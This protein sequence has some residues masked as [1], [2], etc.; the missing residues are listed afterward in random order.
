MRHANRLAWLGF[1]VVSLAGCS[2]EA[3]TATCPDLPL[4]NL[5]DADTDASEI[6]DPLAEA[7]DAGCITPRVPPTP[8][9]D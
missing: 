1:A 3:G 9:P 5:W 2:E 7:A 6:A 4:Y 8:A